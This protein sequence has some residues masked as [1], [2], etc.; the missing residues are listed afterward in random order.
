VG[1]GALRERGS[2]GSG[3]GP[4]GSGAWGEADRERGASGKGR[5]RQRQVCNVPFQM[6]PLGIDEIA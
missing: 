1:L 4:V 2:E 6:S 3:A 5:E